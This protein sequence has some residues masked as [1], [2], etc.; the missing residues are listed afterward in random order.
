MSSQ[1]GARHPAPDAPTVTSAHVAG[2]G[3][4]AAGTSSQLAATGTADL[5]QTPAHR[6]AAGTAPTATTSG[7]VATTGHHA[8]VLSY[9][10]DAPSQEWGWHGQ[11]SLFAAKG[12]RL[13]LLVFA[14]VM[15]LMLFGNH[16]SNVE[17]WW[18]VAIG[19]IML[20][21]IVWRERSARNERRRLA[22]RPGR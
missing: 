15:F 19:L 7:E 11:W 16:V 17:D 8:P 20:G 5:A 12:S 1:T 21:C 4:Q 18:L 3:A 14:A 10:P 9:N 13:L 22:R 6:P 2:Y